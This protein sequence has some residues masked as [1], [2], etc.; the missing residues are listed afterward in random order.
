M[1]KIFFTLGVIIFLTACEKER[2]IIIQTAPIVCDPDKRELT[3]LLRK[4]A[5]TSQ[6]D[7]RLR[8]LSLKLGH[9]ILRKKPKDPFYA[10]YSRR[11]E[12]ELVLNPNFK[13]GPVCQ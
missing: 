6:E 5:L 10:G 11:D 9:S 3:N 8:H 4:G 7:T 13:L 12:Y 1:L 2:P